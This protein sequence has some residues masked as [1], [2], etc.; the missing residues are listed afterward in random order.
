MYRLVILNGKDK[1]K[2]LVVR[3]PVAFLGRH[4]DCAIQV[5][6]AD[7]LTRHAVLERREDHVQVRAIEDSRLAVNDAVIKSTRLDHDDILQVG[8]TQIQYQLVLETPFFERRRGSALQRITAL[9]VAGVILAEAAVVAILLSGE[10]LDRL[11]GVPPASSLPGAAA[12]DPSPELQAELDDARARLDRLNA[13]SQ[14]Q[15]TE[16]IWAGGEATRL[17]GE[18]KKLEASI[19]QLEKQI[20]QADSA[21]P[22]TE[23]DAAGHPPEAGAAEPDAESPGE[24]VRTPQ[25]EAE[26]LLHQARE[27][28]AAKDLVQSIVLLDQAKRLA[29][30]H[31]PTLLMRARVLEG[32]KRFT[33]AVAEWDS[34]LR[35]VTDPA[36]ME[37]ATAA[38]AHVARLETMAQSGGGEP[39][40]LSAS[41]RGL[42]QR[43]AI[44]S[45]RRSRLPK[46]EGFDEIRMIRFDVT[47]SAL[48]DAI[49]TDAVRI[50]IHFIDKSATGESIHLSRVPLSAKSLEVSGVW[51]AGETKE[52]SVL[53]MVPEGFRDRDAAERGLQL[54][55]YGFVVR[56]RYDGVLQDAKA[57]PGTLLERSDS[58]HAGP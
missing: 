13:Q 11:L 8:G 48:E 25:A 33:E 20:A 9:A 54:Q 21:A 49:R 50:D 58:L 29:P 34:L 41:R 28:V 42:P 17:A 6:D 18:R 26:A 22:R 12:P 23:E 10:R 37:E 43:F 32:Q 39:E 30:D 46:R 14:Q 15:S 35:L 24:T 47:P 45:L 36:L 19:D 3:E 57:F 38:R 44:G 55:F 7:V 16:E 53:Y 27:L 40:R 2:R 1:G 52:F 4:P 51:A 31:V 5:D 56:V